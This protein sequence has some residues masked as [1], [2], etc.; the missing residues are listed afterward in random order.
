MNYDMVGIHN[1]YHIPTEK[2]YTY[3]YTTE[4][5]CIVL[6]F[7]DS[8]II[9]EPCDGVLGVEEMWEGSRQVNGRTVKAIVSATEI[10]TGDFDA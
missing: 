4:K 2:N 3:H 9:I 7:V 8:K 1:N 6:R 10:K 5:G